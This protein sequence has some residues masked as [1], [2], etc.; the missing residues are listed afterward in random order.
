MKI[1]NKI[2][3]RRLLGGA[4]VAFATL[5]TVPQRTFAANQPVDPAIHAAHV[6]AGTMPPDAPAMP[7]SDPALAQ[8]LSELRAKVAQF[9]AALATSAPSMTPAPAGAAMPGMPAA[10]PAANPPMSMG[11]D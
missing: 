7:M 9:E 11:M 10:A 1:Q 4:L 8:Q 6:A 5:L 2:I 3:P